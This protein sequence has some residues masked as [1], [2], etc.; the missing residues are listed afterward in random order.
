MSMREYLP[1][2]PM[3]FCAR[4]NLVTIMQP[5]SLGEKAKRE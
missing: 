4:T 3:D 5:T 2:C 1:F